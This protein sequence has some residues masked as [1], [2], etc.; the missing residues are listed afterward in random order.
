MARFENMQQNQQPT[1]AIGQ[2]S[3]QQQKDHQKQEGAFTVP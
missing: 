2:R 3:P 1:S